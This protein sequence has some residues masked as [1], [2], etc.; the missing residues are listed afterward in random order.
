[1]STSSSTHQNAIQL[2]KFHATAQLPRPICLTVPIQSEQDQNVC[3]TI[4]MNN[5]GKNVPNLTRNV[6]LD[7][8]QEHQYCYTYVYALSTNVIQRQEPL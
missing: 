5:R 6:Q 1:M 7:M 3:V 8:T 2:D 4:A